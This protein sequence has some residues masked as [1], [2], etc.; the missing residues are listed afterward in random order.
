MGGA[1]KSLLTSLT[2]DLRK[3]YMA[4][5]SKTLAMSCHWLDYKDLT[6]NAI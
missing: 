6:K 1:I 5:Q 2:Q 3:K 4:F